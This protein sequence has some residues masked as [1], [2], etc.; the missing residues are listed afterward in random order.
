MDGMKRLALVL[1]LAAAVLPASAPAAGCRPMDC[2]PSGVALGHGL[3]AVLPQGMTGNATVVDL[4]SGKPQWTLP[5][6]ALNGHMLVNQS[7]SYLTWHDA[8]TGRETGSAV[9]PGYLAGS[10][11]DGKRAVLTTTTRKRTTFTIVTP[12]AKRSLVLRGQNWGFDALADGNLYLLQYLKNG[13]EVRRFDLAAN[14]LVRQP[15]KDPHESGLIWGTPWTRVTSPDGRYVFTLYVGQ[16]GGAMV[17]ELDVRRAVARCIDLPGT[18]DFNKATSYALQLSPD[19]RTL[20]AASPGYGRVVGIDVASR[21]VRTAFRFKPAWQLESPGATVA[22]VSPRGDRLAIALGTD[23]YVIAPA[24]HSVV[25]W[26]RSAGALAFSP[27]GSRLWLAHGRVMRPLRV[28][29]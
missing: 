28:D 4:R 1:V 13:Y 18:G 19:A 8:Y 10:S 12:G 3:F 26:N 17:H 16:N 22:A 6:G 25:H 7:G 24:A 27:D 20:W 23:V 21:T 15:L 29:G 9:A 11:Q 14:K 2:A 5:G